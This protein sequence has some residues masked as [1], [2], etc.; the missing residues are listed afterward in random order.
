MFLTMENENVEDI[1]IIM[2][3]IA[4]IVSMSDIGFASKAL[5]AEGHDKAM[6]SHIT[7]IFQTAS[8]VF[9]SPEHGAALFAGKQQGHI[10]SR[11]ANP[12]V[13]AYEKVVATLEQGAAA[14]AFGSGMGAVSASILS[15]IQKGDS[16]MVGDTLYGLFIL[17][18]YYICCLSRLHR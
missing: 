13:E 18:F 7:P 3:L 9:D 8:F 11:L 15:F 5:H 12:T 6:H 17:F 14:A 16:V 10:Y 4:L 1:L 2:G